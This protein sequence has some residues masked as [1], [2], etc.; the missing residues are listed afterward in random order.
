MNVR[1]S[2]LHFPALKIWH[3]A[4]KI[5]LRSVSNYILHLFR[6]VI[7]YAPFFF[8][9][10]LF[11][12]CTSLL[13]KLLS[14]LEQQHPPTPKAEEEIF[15]TTFTFTQWFEKR[16][17]MIKKSEYARRFLW[18]QKWGKKIIKE[19]KCSL[20]R[21]ISGSNA[22]HRG[23]KRSLSHSIVCAY[24]SVNVVTKA[25]R[26]RERDSA[27]YA[28]WWCVFS[29]ACIQQLFNVTTLCMEMCAVCT[30][31]WNGREG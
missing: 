19:K 17:R 10:R 9:S 12:L 31:V 18:M 4:G 5:Q 2:N 3:C 28:Q 20:Y 8:S 26:D 14:S 7:L 23:K 21:K 29:M 11:S 24:V 15:E 22:I 6:R 1:G 13:L 16:L 30:R 25:C 27:H